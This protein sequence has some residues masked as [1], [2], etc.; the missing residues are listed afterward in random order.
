[1]R[2]LLAED[3]QDLNRI[4]K[5]KLTDEGYTVDACLYGREALD[6]FLLT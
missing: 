2:L 1:M 4:L 6:L 5:R 3:E